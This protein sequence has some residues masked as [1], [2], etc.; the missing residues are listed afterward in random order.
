MLLKCSKSNIIEI[1]SKK[2][3]FFFLFNNVLIVN[4][5]HKNINLC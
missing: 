5:Y 2:K 3:G 4:L 1:K